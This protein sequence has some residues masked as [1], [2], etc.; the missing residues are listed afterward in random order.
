MIWLLLGGLILW[1]FLVAWEIA[2]SYRQERD[3]ESYRTS[4]GR[5]MDRR[6]R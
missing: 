6:D 4:Q 3:Q 5:R 1:A 2:D